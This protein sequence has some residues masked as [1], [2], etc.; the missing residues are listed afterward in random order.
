VAALLV[1]KVYD[2]MKN[3]RGVK[4][5]GL[6]VLM[7]IPFITLLLPFTTIS[8]SIILIVI[9]MIV[10]GIVMGTHETIM[11]CAIADITPFYKRG[12]GFGIFNTGYGLALLIGSALMGW[13]YDLNQTGIIIAFSCV[14]EA[15]AVFPVHKMVHTVKAGEQQNPMFMIA[16]RDKSLSIKTERYSKQPTSSEIKCLSAVHYESLIPLSLLEMSL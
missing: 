6:T 3:K 2:R 8:S 5:G 16:I 15:I 13:L 7:A 4:T 14:V 10:F 11:R 12:T 9:G 1:G